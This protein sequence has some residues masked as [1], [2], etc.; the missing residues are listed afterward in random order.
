MPTPRGGSSEKTRGCGPFKRDVFGVKVVERAG[1]SSPLFS[2]FFSVGVA[3]GLG[4]EAMGRGTVGAGDANA[5]SVRFMP[6][7]A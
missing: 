7:A 2:E 5:L 4:R 6:S 1:R 3:V